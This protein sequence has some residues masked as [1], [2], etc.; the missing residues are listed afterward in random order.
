MPPTVDHERRT[1]SP[2]VPTPEG[3]STSS[4]KVVAKRA[5]IGPGAPLP[6]ASLIQRAFG[7]HDISQIRSYEDAVAHEATTEL[8][9]YAFTFGNA[10]VFGA[11]PSLFIAAHEA[12]HVVQ[13]RAGRR[14]AGDLDAAG[15]ELEQH[16]DAVAAAVVAGRSAE[17]LLDR[18]PAGS[19]AG[20]EVQR[21][22]TGQPITATQYVDGTLGSW[23]LAPMQ[24]V[25]AEHLEALGVFAKGPFH[26][27]LGD[28]FRQQML[29]GLRLQHHLETFRLAFTSGSTQRAWRVVGAEKLAAL[30]APE[31]LTAIVDRSRPLEYLVDDDGQATGKADRGAPNAAYVGVVGL[32]LANALARRYRESIQRVFPRFGRKF[33]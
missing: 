26:D 5:V 19:A 2:K 15:D 23:Q 33:L 9:A 3:T 11:S 24:H 16:A 7:R 4:P 29:S 25:V 10:V 22:A 20:S 32:E 12:A 31:S 13:Q 1:A 27:V 17:S 21:K 28:E 8:G 14:P 6:H 18:M 30:V